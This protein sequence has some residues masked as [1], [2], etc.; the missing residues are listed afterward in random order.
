MDWMGGG[1]GGG[2]GGELCHGKHLFNGGGGGGGEET[3]VLNEDVKCC[4]FAS[5][6]LYFWC[7]LFKVQILKLIPVYIMHVV[8]YSSTLMPNQFTQS[9]QNGMLNKYI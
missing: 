8:R 7:Y 1:G 5:K 4:N 6:P 3:T 9:K 2:V